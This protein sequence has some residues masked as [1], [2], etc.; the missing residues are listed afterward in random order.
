MKNITIL[1]SSHS[2]AYDIWH[3]TSH[4]LDKYFKGELKI[5]LGANGEDKKEFCPKD[6]IYINKGEDKSF[7]K[8]LKSYLDEIED[9]YFILMLDDFI[10]LEEVN[11]SLIKKAFDFIMENKGVYLRL[12]PNP[13]G[14][15]KIDKYFSQ[16]DVKNQVP[17]ITS[18]QMTIWRKDFLE[19]LLE[20]D[21]NPWEFEIKAGKTKEALEHNDKFFVTNF[22]FI[23]YTHFVEKG[24]FYPFIKELAKKEDLDFISDREFWSEKNL[25]KFKDPFFKKFIRNLI[26]NKYKNSLRKLIGKKEL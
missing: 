21:F 23:K 6:W 18:L 22:D 1:I 4:F 26:P 17:Y 7:S 15:K 10:I 2:N 20:Y 3:I 12:K 24:K 16:I 5:Y 14:D 8:S 9:E 11:N 25:K 13:K 19:K